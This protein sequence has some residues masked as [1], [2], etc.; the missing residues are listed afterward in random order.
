MRL[1]IR[2]N[3]CLNI[4]TQLY[5]RMEQLRVLYDIFN[6]KIM[7]DMDI[8]TFFNLVKVAS[9]EMGLKI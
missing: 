8:Q 4:Q 6:I 9:E 5:V 7:N 3:H 1:L 2:D